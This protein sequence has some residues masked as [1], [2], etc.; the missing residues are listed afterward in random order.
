MERTTCTGGGTIFPI[1]ESVIGVEG[2]LCIAIPISRIY[3]FRLTNFPKQ[4]V[5]EI[6]LR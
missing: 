4:M 2:V 6:K 5:G 1:P 3:V